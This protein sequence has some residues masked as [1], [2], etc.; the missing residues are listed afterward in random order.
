MLYTWCA[1]VINRLLGL[2]GLKTLNSQFIFSYALIFLLAATSGIALYLSMSIN[3]QTINIAGRQRMLSQKMAKEALLVAVNIENTS[4]LQATMQMFDRSHQ[5]IIQGNT[6]QGMNPITDEDI[7]QQ[8]AVVGRL[9]QDYRELLLA[10]VQ[11]PSD[12]GQ[13]QIFRESPRILKEMNTAVVMMTEAANAIMRTQLLLAFACVLSILV[14]VVLGRAFG[15]RLLMDK[16]EEL[17][18]AMAAVGQGD[19]QQRLRVEYAENEIGQMFQAYN[20]MVTQVAD[21]LRAVNEVAVRTQS[22]V[23]QVVQ[24]TQHT[25]AGVAQQYADI[26]QVA[27]A[28][29]QMSATIQ[30]VARHAVAAADSAQKADQ[31]ASQGEE[32]VKSTATYIRELGAQLENTAQTLYQLEQETSKVGLVLEVITGIAEQTNLLA[33]NA[34]IEA[35]RAGEQ[36]RGFAVVADEVRTLAGRT[37]SS[38][39]EISQTIQSLQMQS[40]AAVT[41]MSHSSEQAQA[42]QGLTTQAQAAIHAL[43]A[44]VDAMAQMNEQIA[45][46]AEQ[47]T[48]AADE[49]DARVVH[50]SELAHKTRL[51]AGDVVKATQGI[52][53]E[54][55]QLA[56]LISQFRT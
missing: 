25:E 21:M 37:Q 56:R 5:D 27:S 29:T 36:G 16:I 8:M 7:L 18:H 49:I 46:A 2:F 1:R 41:S 19:F 32:V 14:L 34:A 44:E 39:Q 47:Q 50:I 51:D 52:E 55:Q 28:M 17:R 43:V 38:I 40:K 35:A 54:I 33:L 11:A 48:Q 23:Q 6:Q 9:W 4:N 22:H 30:E 24:A 26:D 45:A 10:Y 12:Q 20:Q 15:M 42:N 3:P 13:Q 31:E 53:Q